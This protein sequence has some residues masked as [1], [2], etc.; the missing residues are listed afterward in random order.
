MDELQILRGFLQERLH[1]EFPDSVP[2]QVQCVIKN[3]ELIILAQHLPGSLPEPQEIFSV[4]KQSLPREQP[5]I[6]H[7]VKLYLRLAGQ[8]RPYAF[9]RFQVEQPDRQQEPSS[10][11]PQTSTTSFHSSRARGVNEI[12]P[13]PPLVPPPPALRT[14]KSSNGATLSVPP[15]TNSEQAEV[16]PSSAPPKT[17]EDEDEL[18]FKIFRDLGRHPYDIT[19]GKLPD[20]QEP[21]PESSDI[22]FQWSGA[23]ETD[24]TDEKDSNQGTSPTSV[25]G[26][27]PPAV[28]ERESIPD[29]WF[30]SENTH[31]SASTT[32]PWDGAIPNWDLEPDDVRKNTPAQESFRSG[33]IPTRDFEQKTQKFK[34]FQPRRP[35]LPVLLAGG[36]IAAAFFLC[37]LYF[38]T[39]P[40]VIGECMQIAQ[41]QQLNNKSEQMLQKPKSGKEILE[42]QQQLK[43]AIGILETIPSWSSHYNEAQNLVQDYQAQARVVDDVIAALKKGATASVKSQNPPHT[44]SEW[45]EIQKRWREAALG[46]EQVPKDSNIYNLAR[47]KQKAYKANL[48]IANKRLT[49]EQ[50]AKQLL[51]VAKEA[52]KKAEA[53]Q[54]VAQTLESWYLVNATWQMAVNRL[55]DIPSGTT[56]YEDAQQLLPEYQNKLAAVRQRTVTEQFAANTYKQSQ[57]LAQQAK[58]YQAINQWSQAV[59]HWNN[60]LSY[61]K[62]IPK[63]TDYYTKTADAANAYTEALKQAQAQ[64]QLATLLQQA[65]SDLKQTCTGKPIICTFAVT[66][67][68]IKVRLTPDYMQKVRNTALSARARN[69]YNAQEGVIKHVL[70]L[71]EALEAISDNAK[72]RLEVYTPDGALRQAHNPA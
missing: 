52:A 49:V 57:R 63:G 7:Q 18:L 21:I 31:Q 2:F 5:E 22:P 4:L 43:S 15:T 61:L 42:A 32:N 38:L 3:G 69:D 14:P 70:T 39:R 9:D 47:Q 25:D 41:A 28:E 60:A 13:P 10:T 58:N 26:D 71:G 40:C 51:N 54:G 23:D 27:R 62:Q 72:I 55:G 11:T 24:E 34:G 29:S 67:D 65:R 68:L 36:G 48:A 66:K 37:S 6:P 17:E 16:V 33:S 56:A 19:D 30:A 64:L 46:L 44:M 59:I 35:S 53:R 50:Q 8:N 45:L 12:L 1:I 20:S